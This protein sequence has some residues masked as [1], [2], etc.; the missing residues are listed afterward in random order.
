[1][2]LLSL[3]SLVNKVDSGPRPDPPNSPTASS[4]RPSSTALLPQSLPSIQLRRQRSATARAGLLP[5]SRPTPIEVEGALF[6]APLVSS[7]RSRNSDTLAGAFANSALDQPP[8]TSVPVGPTRFGYGDEPYSFNET[9]SLKTNPWTRLL[10]SS[11][12]SFRKRD[13]TAT[14]HGPPSSPNNAP[15]P[16]PSAAKAASDAATVVDPAS[17]PKGGTATSAPASP[18]TAVRSL[19]ANK[20]PPPVDGFPP[21]R[22][23]VPITSTLASVDETT[24][25]TT[26]AL[27]PPPSPTTRRARREAVIDGSPSASGGSGSAVGGGSGSSRGERSAVDGSA[28]ADGSAPDGSAL[29][30]SALDGSALDGSD[31][32]SSSSGRR[33]RLDGSVSGLDGTADGSANEVGRRR[34]D[35]SV[36]GLDGTADGS[37]N[38]VGRRRLDGSVSGLDG[39]A[40]GSA[41]EVGRSGEGERS[42]ADDSDA[43]FQDW[44]RRPAP[45]GRTLVPHTLA[46]QQARA[47]L[48]DSEGSASGSG[49]AGERGSWPP[50]GLHSRFSDWTTTG[51]TSS[52]SGG[53][54]P[55][56]QAPGIPAPVPVPVSIDG[57]RILPLV[58]LA[59]VAASSVS[60]D[61]GRLSRAKAYEL[62]NVGRRAST[63]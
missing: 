15:R 56:G 2:K 50:T 57:A 6:D 45:P 37:A 3:R 9:P 14:A 54:S 60:F 49:G 17:S 27:N 43:D 53:R 48:L 35:G 41:N 24:S 62:R 59:D 42:D 23:D 55:G 5:T 63:G 29:D 36:S 11:R 39:T 10:N 13:S 44:R 18:S 28:A 58:L 1:M 7:P 47:V 51:T 22:I 20:S 30:G 16:S 25:T 32:G 21:R 40:D 52:A 34:L 61:L 46:Q 4:S 19:D 33:R 31:L 12:R 26:P 8:L 38:E